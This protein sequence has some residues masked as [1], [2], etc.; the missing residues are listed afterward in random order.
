MS[1]VC[2]KTSLLEAVMIASKAV[3]SRSSISAINGNIKL[4]SR[5]GSLEVTGY[6]MELG[7]KTTIDVDSQGDFSILV[8]ARTFAAIL[9]KLPEDVA[10]FQINE[11]K[12]LSIDSGAVHFKINCGSG[13]DYPKL[14]NENVHSQLK[15]KQKVLLQ[16]I[17]GTAFAASIDISRPTLQGMYIKADNTLKTVTTVAI[18][19]FRLAKME[20]VDF[21]IENDFTALIPATTMSEISRLLESN[22][23]P[24][25]LKQSAN[26]IYIHIS[27][28]EI[29]SSIFNHSQY[30]DYDKIIPAAYETEA[31]LERSVLLNAIERSMLVIS[32]DS[33]K[34]Y[35][36]DMIF[37]DE[38]VHI[39]SQSNT[40]TFSEQIEINKLGSDVYISFNP[41]FWV[42][43][44]KAIT[45]DHVVVKMNGNMGPTIITPEKGTDFTYLILP[46]RK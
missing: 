40:G 30:M 34:N 7:I 5:N 38:E 22:D 26:H 32:T 10:V 25:V 20:S 21:D 4:E 44:L 13:D 9:K 31:T 46:L 2:N 28:T 42:D 18:D 35:P 24:V 3:D 45:C 16:M 43:A 27:D 8:N 17:R 12:G 39:Q 19:G 29:S 14:S 37:S 15:I 1:F 23:E 6:N 33:P 41:R 11:G 36:V